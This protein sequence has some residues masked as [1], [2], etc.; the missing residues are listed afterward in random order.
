MSEDCLYRGK[1]KKEFNTQLFGCLYYNE[2]N[3]ITFHNQCGYKT[4]D[5]RK[6]ELFKERKETDE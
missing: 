1:W 6:C 5:V 3:N 4:P 2:P